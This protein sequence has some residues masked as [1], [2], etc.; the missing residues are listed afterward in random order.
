MH[1]VVIYGAGITSAPDTLDRGSAVY[2]V[3]HDVAGLARS[4]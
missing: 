1:A 4:L 2:E 3:P